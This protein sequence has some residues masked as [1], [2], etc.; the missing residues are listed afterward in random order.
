[1]LQ[2]ENPNIEVLTPKL[3]AVRFSLIPMIPQIS[4]N[5]DPSINWDQTYC[6]FTADYQVVFL[7]KDFKFFE[8]VKRAYISIIRMKPKQIRK[9]LSKI[10]NHPKN[11]P[12]DI[13]YWGCLKGELERRKMIKGGVT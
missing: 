9:E 11:T 4:W 2:H 6:Q 8:L 3:Y 12:W 5:P 7:N 10:G 13:V 1:M